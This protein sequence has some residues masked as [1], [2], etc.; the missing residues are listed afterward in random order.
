MF[1]VLRLSVVVSVGHGAVPQQMLI[2]PL[3]WAY[4]ICWFTW[5]SKQ[6]QW[7]MWEKL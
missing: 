4:I 7:R 2:C 1:I 3:L 5:N 6:D